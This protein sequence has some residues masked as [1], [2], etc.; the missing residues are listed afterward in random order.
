[1]ASGIQSI[2]NEGVHHEPY[3]V[4]SIDDAVGNRIYTH[5]S[6]GTE[7]LDRNVALTAIDVMKGVLPEARLVAAGRFRE[8]PA[9]LRQ[10]RDPAEQL[11]LVLRGRHAGP[12][13]R[14]AGP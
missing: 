3:Y 1:M 2:A 10:D 9:C 5:S 4:E 12:G 6:P 13:D 14:R 7:V 11:D 8:P